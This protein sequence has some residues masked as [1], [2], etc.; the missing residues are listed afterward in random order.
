MKQFIW[1]LPAIL[2]VLSVGL[3]VWKAY[4]KGLFLSL[5]QLGAVAI[6]AILAF[7]LTKIFVNPA[8]LDF[9]GLGASLADMI[10]ED[11]MSLPSSLNAFIKALP[12]AMLALVVF[13]VAFVIL[14]A[15]LC[16]VIRGLNK[17]HGWSEKVLC[18]PKSKLVALAPGLASAVLCL[19]AELVLVNG[20]LC[21]ASGTLTVVR[22][23]SQ[24]P[25]LEEVA[26]VVQELADSPA[27]QLTDDLGCRWAF[28]SLTTAEDNGEKFSVGE[29][30]I[31]A[32]KLVQGL[33]KASAF[34]PGSE[35]MP[36]GD[37]FRALGEYMQENPE[38]AGTVVDVLKSYR[39]ELLPPETIEQISQAI[40]VD[41]APVEK[42]I[43]E[44]EAATAQEDISTICNVVAILADRELLPGDSEELDVDAFADP[45]LQKLILEELQK[46]ERLCGLLGLN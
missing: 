45:E 14:K 23:F 40:G 39:E 9:M 44:L 13:T 43:Q 38:A 17:K 34:L 25:A 15:I 42:Y 30:M 1:L 7:V 26:F 36:D 12:T 6:S 24:E 8:R 33:E 22:V 37:D 27:I 28:Y 41:T 31:G 5:L 2:M 11:G 35:K 3:R 4:R 21:V 46:N 18:F 10:A 29:R 20:L 16:A 32:V 19:L